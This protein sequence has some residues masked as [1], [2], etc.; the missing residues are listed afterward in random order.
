MKQYDGVMDKYICPQQSD[1]IQLYF[2]NKWVKSRAKYL[3]LLAFHR[4]IDA[5]MFTF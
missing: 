4:H 2:L 1:Y 3:L 5:F